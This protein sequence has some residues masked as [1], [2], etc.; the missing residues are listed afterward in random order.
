MS[1]SIIQLQHDSRLDYPSK[2][3]LPLLSHSVLEFAPNTTIITFRDSG[4]IKPKIIYKNLNACSRHIDKHHPFPASDLIF[5]GIESDSPLAPLIL[6]DAAHQLPIGNTITLLEDNNQ[7]PYLEREYFKNAFKVEIKNSHQIVYKKTAA[8]LAEEDAGL[9][10]WSFC[11]PTGPSDTTGLNIIV[12]RILELDIPEKE[13]LLC[14]RPDKGFLYWDKVRIVG[15]DIPAP[16]IWITRKK[17]VLAQEAKYENLCILH[18][19]V[20]LPSN[21]LETIRKFGDGFSFAGFQSLWFDD[22]YNLAPTRYSDYGCGT[23]PHYANLI[24]AGKENQSTL[25]T[26]E[27]FTEIEKQHFKIGNPL[28]YQ[29][30]N[31]LTGSLYITKRKVWLDT[32]QNE[33]LY[34]AEFEDIEHA[35]RCHKKGI[36]HR[37]IPGAFTQ[38]LYAR[39]LLFQAGYSTYISSNGLSHI[40]RNA[41]PLPQSWQKPLI[42]LSF[43]DASKRLYK[44]AAK[45]CKEKIQGLSS[46]SSFREKILFSISS[47][48]IP[49]NRNAINEFIDD[50]ERDILCDQLGFHN[51]QYL[52]DEFIRLKKFAKREFFGKH[53]HELIFQFAQRPHEKRFYRDITEYFP[54]RNLRI[55]MG[56]FLTAIRLSRKNGNYF[57]HLAGCRGYYKAILESTPFIDYMEKKS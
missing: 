5:C 2:K 15:E 33:N 48:E 55:K 47:A 22:L 24:Y 43:A 29:R 7:S 11:I 35:A 13:I 54:R 42:K 10:R 18:D 27:L 39:P 31:Y 38:T 4:K 40:T 44:F 25:Y 57:H 49:F 36:P 52:L 9:D 14:G 12:K 26:K 1:M 21:F 6:W 17:N 56:S 20:F 46:R 51:K 34:W 23:E 3:D 37:I 28:R 50:V 53:F 8:L 41:F 30:T 32:P 19:R 16:P 45:Y